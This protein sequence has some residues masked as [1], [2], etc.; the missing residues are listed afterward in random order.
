MPNT[1]TNIFSFPVPLSTTPTLFSAW[2]FL[3]RSAFHSAI[4]GKWP[5][6]TTGTCMCYATLGSKLQNKRRKC[7]KLL[8]IYRRRELGALRTA[9]NNGENWNHN[10]LSTLRRWKQISLNPV[11]FCRKKKLVFLLFFSPKEYCSRN[12]SIG[13]SVLWLF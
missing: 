11:P 4:I 1:I 5:P 9:H 13:L 3:L 10:E 6:H 2:C 7:N 8:Q 12:F